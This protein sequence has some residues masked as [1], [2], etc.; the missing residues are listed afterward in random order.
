MDLYA[1]QCL[2]SPEGIESL[3]S[4]VAGGCHHLVCVLGTEPRPSGREQ[5]LF[6]PESS[7]P[8]PGYL[9]TFSDYFENWRRRDI[10]PLNVSMYISPKIKGF[11]INRLC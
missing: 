5:V 6:T 2:R 9:F 7:H 1:P 4:G 10:W 3:G 11:F 8:P